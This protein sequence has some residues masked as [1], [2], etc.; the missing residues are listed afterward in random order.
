MK[1]KEMLA[2]LWSSLKGHRQK[3]YDNIMKDHRLGL[4]VENPEAVYKMIKDRLMEYTET[5]TEKQTRVKSEYDA[6]FKNQLSALNWYTA[7][8][9]A[10]R[11]LR[12]AGMPRTERDAF[13]DYVAKCGT[14][15]NQKIL[16]DLIPRVD[17]TKEDGSQVT[18]PP[19]TWEE[20]HAV[21]KRLESIQASSKALQ[22]SVYRTTPQLGDGADPLQGLSKKQKKKLKKQLGVQQP[23]YQQT[24]LADL[25][26]L[27]QGQ[28]MQLYNQIMANKGKGK[29]KGK[30]GSKGGKGKGGK[31][32][33]GK[34]KAKGAKGGE[35]EETETLGSERK[36]AAAGRLPKSS[37]S[38]VGNG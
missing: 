21:V 26:N 4:A 28:F 3:A 12:N 25:N 23:A 20:A 38:E 1:W 5:L 8:E 31:G 2:V 32:K 7:W 17:R 24:N 19:E 37:N 34:G 30:G 15:L 13:L 27:S 16:N 22:R 18:R 11:N 6:L 36:L 33:G 9:K 35:E 14:E 29:G 10:L